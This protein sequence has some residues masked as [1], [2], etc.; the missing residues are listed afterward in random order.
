[1][2]SDTTAP[3][4]QPICLITGASRG[5]GNAL[6]HGF[7][8]AGYHIIAVARTVGALEALDDELKAAA[9]EQGG[10]EA[11]KKAGATLVPLDIRDGDAIDRLGGALHQRFG[12]LDVV[13]SNAATMEVLSPVAQ[14]A[15]KPFEDAW[16]TNCQGPYRLIRSLDPLLR[17]SARGGCFIGVTCA[18]AIERKPFW[19]TYGASKAAFEAMVLSYA[20]ELAD[21]PLRVNLVDPGPM[22]TRL[23]TLAFPG[24]KEGAQPD[25]ATKVD[26]FI[27][28][29]SAD[30]K[31]H[32]ERIVL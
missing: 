20:A 16:R 11:A 8:K 23:R 22:A 21:D 14:S 4:D 13:I 32:G 6:A 12:K 5:L 25:P 30:D 15:P 1:M 19:G 31:R 17:Q 24:E 10:A 29:A 18:S 9:A 27:E 26:A 3:T 2:P 28:L 7:A